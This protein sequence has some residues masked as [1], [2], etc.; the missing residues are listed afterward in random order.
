M[1]ISKAV[2]KILVRYPYL[3]EYMGLGIVN[4]RAL[5]RNIKEDVKRE[6]GREVNIQSVVSAV[7]RYPVSKSG[8]EK[9]KIFQVLS[10]SEV[11][12]RYDV[13]TL[14]ILIDAAASK[15]DLH[16]I[17]GGLIMIQGIETLTVVVEEG[18]IGAFKEKFKDAVINSNKDLASVIVKSPR[19]IADTPGVIAHLA[20]TLAL[21]K[22]N[23][24]E[25]MSSYTET[26][27]IVN[28]KDALKTVEAIR[29]EIKRVRK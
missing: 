12:L 13:G 18:L 11:S 10:A 27:F 29:R 8:R 25:M 28:E 20:N 26:W 4:S 24:V 7:R 1:D 22:I 17:D 2:R 16:E 14:N 9:G 23:V 5:A 3:E 21:E 6:L 19:E 15:I